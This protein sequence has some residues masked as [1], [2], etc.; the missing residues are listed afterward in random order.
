MMTLVPIFFLIALFYSVAGLAGGSA[1]LA[2]LAWCGF[3]RE[4]LVPLALLCNLVVA[5]QATWKLLI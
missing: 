1:Y 2:V 5:G 3:S 4:T